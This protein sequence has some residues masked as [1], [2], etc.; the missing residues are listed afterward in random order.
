MD[1][2]LENKIAFVSGSTAGIGF[3]IAQRFLQEGAQVI[4]NGRTKQ[5]VDKAVTELKLSVGNSKVSGIAA[6]F[7]KVNEV[8]KLLSELP[9][10]RHPN[11]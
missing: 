6:D 5:T 2:D 3:A 8:N 4:I 9:D 11:K 1:L 10:A 7:S